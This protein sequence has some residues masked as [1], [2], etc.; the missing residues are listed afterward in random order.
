M[1]KKSFWNE[2][3]CGIKVKSII[4]CLVVIACVYLV[5]DYYG[6]FDKM[7]VT[8]GSKVS[9]KDSY[10]IDL[11]LAE[12]RIGP[13]ASVVANQY[14]NYNAE[15]NVVAVQ[16]DAERMDNT[17]H[18][19][20]LIPVMSLYGEREVVGTV[21]Q[22]GVLSTPVNP[23]TTNVTV[24]VKMDASGFTN[25]NEIF[26]SSLSASAPFLKTAA[27][28]EYSPVLMK[29]GKPVVNVS[30]TSAM[31]NFTWTYSEVTKTATIH[32]ELDWEGINEMTSISD[33]IVIPIKSTLSDKPLTIRLIK[34][35]AI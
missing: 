33:E 5:A 3:I 30:G 23:V 18:T 35:S 8:D 20:F 19:T 21:V 14:V 15:S 32:F 4:A 2:E 22:D 31:K 28:K 26:T 25:T 1:A 34:N 13:F 6:A 17:T 12:M 9:D 11:S 24:L 27:G 29:D 10:K 7:T 16:I